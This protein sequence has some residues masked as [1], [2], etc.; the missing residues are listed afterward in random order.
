VATGTPDRLVAA[1][2]EAGL[3]DP[4]PVGWCTDHP[5][6]HTLDGDPLPAGGWR[7]RF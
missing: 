2:R 4:L 3:R 6:Q 7:H 1:F 5:G